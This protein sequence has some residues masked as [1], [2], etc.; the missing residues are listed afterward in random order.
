MSDYSY[1]MHKHD[2][3][4]DEELDIVS[5]GVPV[6]LPQ[7][8]IE[9]RMPLTTIIYPE[10][11]WY[12]AVYTCGR[13]REEVTVVGEDSGGVANLQRFLLFVPDDYSSIHG[14]APQWL[15]GV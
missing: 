13:R 7:F 1:L 5:S 15:R 14:A 10:D 9:R 6:C 3:F 4:T 8:G 12:R 11:K 2:S